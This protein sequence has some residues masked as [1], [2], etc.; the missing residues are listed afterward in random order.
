[1]KHVL[2]AIVVGA[3]VASAA[4][5]QAPA[6]GVL[7][8]L[9]CYNVK[10]KLKPAATVDMPTELQPEFAQRQCRLL[11]VTKFC[12]PSSKRVTPPS[13][14]PAIV[15]QPLSDD[16]I[17]YQIRCPDKPVVPAKLVADQFGQR[18][19]EKYRPVEICAPAR[20]A[21]IPC[22]SI[23]SG[24]QCGGGC[25]DPAATCHFD[26]TLK[27]C[28]CNPTPVCE[29]KPDKFGMCGGPCPAPQVCLP[30]LDTAG[31]PA[32]GCQDLPPPPCGV[33]TGAAVCGGSCTDPT[34][35][36][37]QGPV[38]GPPC[39]CQPPEPGCDLVGS[40]NQCGGPC[41]VPG[42]EC[43]LDPAS[44]KCRCVPP[45]QPCG[46]NPFTGQCGGDCGPNLICRFQPGTAAPC[47]CVTP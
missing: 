8:H 14:G 29:G 18:R 2:A 7:D 46:Q 30:G 40:T 47:V 36:C 3:A 41:T 37:I 16:Y 22:T 45:P 42:L 35:V 31:K 17:C 13:T 11:K 1:M 39:I 23:G 43:R 10:D 12:V 21:P 19:Q 9:I 44:N 15:G 32:C 26:D 6:P 33:N 25:T 4:M 34:A 24:K 20:K 27:E 28:T 5:A 38:G